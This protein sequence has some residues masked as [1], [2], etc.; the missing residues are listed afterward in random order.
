M[1]LGKCKTHTFFEDKINTG[2]S[3]A[4][5]PNSCNRT[6]HLFGTTSAGA[7]AASVKIQ[8]SNNGTVWEDIDTLSLTLSTTVDT[9]YFEM[10]AAW[11]FVRGNVDSIS[12]TDAAVTLVMGSE[13]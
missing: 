6:F 2:A 3:D 10:T 11:K 13:Y 4:I 9:D 1:S 7:G 8:A 12:G 5:A